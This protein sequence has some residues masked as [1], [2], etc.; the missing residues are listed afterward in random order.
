MTKQEIQESA[1]IRAR[2][3]TFNAILKG[4]AQ[5]GVE[6][7]TDQ[8]LKQCYT[9]GLNVGKEFYPLLDEDNQALIAFGMVDVG[10]AQSLEFNYRQRVADV[11]KEAVNEFLRGAQVGLM[12][13]AKESGKMIS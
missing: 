2:M 7:M 6:K 4:F 10:I 13:A 5:T 1:L 8:E 3:A 11:K 12:Q 9:D